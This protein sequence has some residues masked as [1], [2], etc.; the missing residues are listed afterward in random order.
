MTTPQLPTDYPRTEKLSRPA[1]RFSFQLPK[2][3]YR[4][5]KERCLQEGVTLFMILLAGFQ[6]LLHRHSGQTD[7]VTGSPAANRNR[8]ETEGLIGYFVNPL[9]LRTKFCEISTFRDLLA[10]VRETVLGAYAHQDVPFEMIVDEIAPVR[11]MEMSPLFRT[12]FVADNAPARD[13]NWLS[14]LDVKFIP[15]QAG[16]ARLDLALEMRAEK[17]LEGTFVYAADLYKEAT[18]EQ[19]AEH[20]EIILGCGASDPGVT[21]LEIPLAHAQEV[22]DNAGAYLIDSEADFRF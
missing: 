13:S 4:S 15:L 10:C 2:S 8:I 21:I 19:M 6:A 20:L 9:A 16:G 5:L 17:G 14:S 11:N 22:R 7:I 12:W 18:I 3:L 1:G